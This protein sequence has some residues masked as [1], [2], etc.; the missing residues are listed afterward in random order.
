MKIKPL[1]DKVV[2]KRVEAQETTKAGILLP[3]SAQEKPQMSEVVAVGPGGMVDGKDV[4]M[5]LSVGDRVI[6]GKYSGT[7]VKLDGGEY[8]VVSQSDILAVI[9][10]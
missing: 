10:E 4:V 3:G 9:E 8:M 5:T 2:V 7:E 1:L 6:V